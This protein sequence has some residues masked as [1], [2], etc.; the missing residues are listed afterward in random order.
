MR[1]LVTGGTGFIGRHVVGALMERGDQVR[2]LVRGPSERLPDDVE[3]LA[4]DVRDAVAVGRGV[5]GVDAVIHLAASLAV[6]GRQD[7][8][9]PTINGVGPAVVAARCRAAGVPMVHVSSVHALQGAP[10]EPPVSEASAL[11]VDGRRLP[12]DHSKA[13]GQRAVLAE[14]ALGL[15]A[16]I[17][18]PVGVM[19]PGD[20]EPSPVGAA[21]LQMARGEVPGLVAAGFWWVDVR[22]VR[23]AVLAAL[24]R[25]TPGGRYLISG[26][27]R[28]LSDLAWQVHA[29]GGAR[30]PRLVTPLWLAELSAPAAVLY[31]R[32][33]RRRALYSPDSV[34]VLR[35]HQRLDDSLTRRTLGLSPRPIDQS[36]ADALDSFRQAGMLDAVARR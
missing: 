13:I 8:E 11:A 25:G 5:D 6:A 15:D 19:G 1:V 3:A 23:D 30:P 34:A 26:E 17:L 16:R 21:L 22:D 18:N 29:C 36:V 20:L 33:M 4:G 28:T 32:L 24:D 14:V 31:A 7:P 2:V 9:M 27:H 12:Y 10:S 35:G